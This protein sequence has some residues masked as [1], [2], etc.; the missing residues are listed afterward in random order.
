MLSEA[1]DPVGPET[2]APVT[3]LVIEA[4]LRPN[5]VA[6]SSTCTELPESADRQTAEPVD[7]EI[8]LVALEDQLLEAGPRTIAIHNVIERLHR[9]RLVAR[10][11]NR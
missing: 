6:C 1:G 11:E 4:S 3:V 9:R 7:A 5:D 10:P 8:C 2:V